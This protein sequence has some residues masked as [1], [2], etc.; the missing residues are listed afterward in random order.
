MGKINASDKT[1]FENQQKKIKYGNIR[2]FYINIHLKDC[3]DIEFTA[4][5]SELMPEEALTS[6]TISD[7]YRQFAGQA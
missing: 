5:K 6:F 4:C 3:L 7:A 2:N 1:V